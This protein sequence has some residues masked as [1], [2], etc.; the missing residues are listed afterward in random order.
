MRCPNVNGFVFW[1]NIGYIISSQG[2]RSAGVFESSERY[3]EFSTVM[4]T[5]LFF[6]FFIQKRS[7]QGFSGLPVINSYR[8]I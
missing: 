7:Y 8:N 5:C 3:F 6:V 1:L 4:S 2:C